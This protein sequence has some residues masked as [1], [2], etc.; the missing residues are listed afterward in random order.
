MCTFKK[1]NEFIFEAKMSGVESVNDQIKKSLEWKKSTSEAMKNTQ[2]P[3]KKQIYTLRLKYIDA[4]INMLRARLP[5]E[6]AK[7]KAKR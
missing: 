7:E 1:Y 6:M 3:E 5:L 2:S 4:K